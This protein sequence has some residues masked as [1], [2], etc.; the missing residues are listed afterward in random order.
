MTRSTKCAYLLSR[1]RAIGAAPQSAPAS[2][3]QESEVGAGAASV[4]ATSPSAASA[5]ASMTAEGRD[6]AGS[7]DGAE[8]ADVVAG[9]AFSV[10]AAAAAAAEAGSGS[11]AAVAQAAA[12]AAGTQ[13]KPL[14]VITR[15]NHAAVVCTRRVGTIADRT[16][17]RFCEAMG[18]WSVLARSG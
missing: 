17:C 4:H 6:A 10:A 9:A 5:A 7:V 18:A 13:H 15:V 14:K 2:S 11:D 3:F 16:Y 1:L 12:T 8:D